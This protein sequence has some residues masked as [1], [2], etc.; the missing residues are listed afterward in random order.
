MQA[1]SA[2]LSGMQAGLKWLDNIGN[3]VANEDTPGFAENTQSFED[4]LTS[5]VTANATAPGV[6]G[7]LTPPGWNGGTGVVATATENNFAQMPLETTGNQTDLAINGSGFFLV[8]G[9]NGQIELT[10]AGNFQWSKNAAGQFELTT[11]TGEAVL[12]TNGN[13]IVE[14]THPTGSFSVGPDGTVSF[15]SGGAS[16]GTARQQRIAI[17]EIPLPNISLVAQSNNVFTVQPGFTPRIVN[18]AGGAGG[19]ATAAAGT[20][21]QGALAMS[22][23]DLTVQMTDMIQAQQMFAINEEA[24]QLTN[25]MQQDASSLQG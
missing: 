12:D 19:A 18:A 16:S 1:F 7:R 23:V 22:N 10:K 11:P 9:A 2:S 21:Q 17:A 3:N 15:G 25:Q 4:A 20:I 8:R 24:L 14:P 5:A 6:A 13:P